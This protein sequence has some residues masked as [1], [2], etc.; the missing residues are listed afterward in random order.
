MLQT[1]KKKH[2]NKMQYKASM[3]ILSMKLKYFC[4]KSM[5]LKQCMKEIHWKYITEF[6]DG[7]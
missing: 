4:L 7:S 6:Y 3:F 1:L 2:E 5:F